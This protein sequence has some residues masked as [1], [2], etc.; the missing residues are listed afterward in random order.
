MAAKWTIV[1]LDVPAVLAKFESTS[2]LH[3]KALRGVQVCACTML[4]NIYTSPDVYTPDTLPRDMRLPVPGAEA[5]SD[6]Y[7]WYWIAAEP[8]P[9]AVVPAVPPRK[10]GIPKAAQP[11]VVHR[12]HSL[13]LSRTVGFSGEQARVLL[14]SHG[15]GPPGALQRPLRSPQ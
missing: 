5:W 6:L 11:K 14:W 1:A 2:K 8:R 10:V 13:E 7:Q 12:P 9:V 4:R 3:F 15:P